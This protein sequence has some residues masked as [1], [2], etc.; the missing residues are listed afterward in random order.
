MASL[1]VRIEPA[2][3]PDRDTKGGW[4]RSEVDGF[5][6]AL[7]IG[8]ETVPIDE[9]VSGLWGDPA[10]FRD[11]AARQRAIA[12]L[13]DRF[14]DIVEALDGDADAYVPLFWRTAEGVIVFE[15]WAE[16]FL[17][18]MWVRIIDLNGAESDVEAKIQLIRG[19]NDSKDA[20]LQL[21]NVQINDVLF[22]EFDMIGGYDLGR[23]YPHL[24]NHM[25]IAVT[26]TNTRQ[27]IDEIKRENA[28]LKHLVADLSLEAYR[29]KKTAIPPLGVHDGDGA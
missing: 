24:K 25:L 22:D 13:Q 21:I 5:V 2:L 9:W 11:A 23:D 19:D 20:K 15:N 4:W 10:P 27:E 1:E 17:E 14:D 16:G 6:T 26:E 29:L 18:G 3:A 12:A 28:E 7:A 8:P